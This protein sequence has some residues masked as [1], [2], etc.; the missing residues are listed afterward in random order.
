VRRLRKKAAHSSMVA[1]VYSISKDFYDK[2]FRRQKGRCAWCNKATGVRKKLAVDHDHKCC[3][4]STSCGRCV[5]GL[6]CSKCNRH[7]G[8][9]GDNPVAMLRGYQ[10]L[11][12][13]PAQQLMRELGISKLEGDSDGRRTAGVTK[14]VPAVVAEGSR[15]SV[16]P[17]PPSY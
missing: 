10:Y 2:L 3:S 5:R 7:L 15:E 9:L 17:I 12:N 1:R 16:Y 14:K 13:P 8:W 11:I 4:G 6:L